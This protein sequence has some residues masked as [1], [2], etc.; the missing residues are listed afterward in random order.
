ME[1]ILK[2]DVS[3][4]GFKDDVVTVRDGYAQNFLIPKGF[5]VTA[6]ASAKKVLAENL[7]QRSVKLS[8]LKEEAEKTAEKLR[9]LNLK[10]ELLTG[11]DGKIFGSVTPIMLANL[12]KDKGFDVDRRKLHA[13]AET[14]N[15]GTYTFTVDLYKEI[16]AEVSFEIV[17][18]VEAE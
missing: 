16:K 13:P 14:N 1:I 7:R 15:V 5:A 10:V 4:L 9:N 11:K 2:E 12:L 3:N 6:T 8:K 18:K 17:A